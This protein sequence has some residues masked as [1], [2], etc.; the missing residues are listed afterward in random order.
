MQWCQQTTVPGAPAAL[1]VQ[2]QSAKPLTI[3]WYRNGLAIPGATQ[4]CLQWPQLTVADLGIYE[5]ALASPEWTH[6]LKPVEI[7]FNSEGIPTTAARNKLHNAMI[8]GLI[9]SP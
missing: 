2:F 4:A 7:Q 1:C 8:W 6:F 5:V 9:G 3:Q